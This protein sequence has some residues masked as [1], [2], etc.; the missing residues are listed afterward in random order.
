MNEANR[1]TIEA[2]E[3]RIQALLIAHG[4][5]EDQSESVAKCFVMADACGIHTHGISILPAHIERIQRGAY[6]LSPRFNE[7]KKTHAFA[8]VDS[9]NALG[10]CSAK[11]CMEM[12]IENARLEGMFAVYS[13]NCNTYGPAFYYTYLAA[14]QGMIG[15]TFC[16][17]PAAMPAW[18]GKEALLGTNPLAIAI[19]GNEKGPI[20]LDMATSKAAKSKINEARLAGESIPEGWALDQNGHVTTDPEEAIKGLILPMAEHKGFGLA[21]C[22]DIL[23]G[24]LSGAAYSTDVKKFYSQESGCMNV[25]QVF[26]AIDPRIVLSDE[27]Y[28]KV[29][30]YITRIHRT[31][32]LPG[33]T[34]RFPG[35]L[36]LS[37]YE[38]AKRQGIEF[39]AGAAEK[40]LEMLKAE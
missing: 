39:D 26:A 13:M 19:P 37:H 5:P 40:I 34:P 14:I 18:G 38:K 17:T 23:A 8:R 7:I 1:W 12:A 10:P 31:A 32:A 36:K 33:Q 4:V 25:G 35:E 9:D 30:D 28:D 3:Q 2:L 29:D 15:I 24:V 21:L 6:N 11:H 22:I 27:F 20:L 16:N